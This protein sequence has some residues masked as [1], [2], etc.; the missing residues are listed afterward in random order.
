MKYPLQHSFLGLVRDKIVSIHFLRW[1][2]TGDERVVFF[3]CT[4]IRPK[5]IIWWSIEW[6]LNCGLY[7]CSTQSGQKH[8]NGWTYWQADEAKLV[9]A[10]S[11]DDDD[12]NVYYTLHGYP[13]LC[14]LFYSI[15]LYIEQ[16][17]GPTD[18]SSSNHRHRYHQ[19]FVIL[20][21]GSCWNSEIGYIHIKR[22][23]AGES[24]SVV[25]IKRDW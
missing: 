15:G 3:Y 13:F 2:R 7:P 10:P 17:C 25:V 6:A 5:T 16:C 11:N 1:W 22:Y 20:A 14:L 23:M 8:D 21:S 9:P 24:R 18:R 12:N 4:F 19:H